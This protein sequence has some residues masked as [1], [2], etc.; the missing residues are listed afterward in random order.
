[1][2]APALLEAVREVEEEDERQQHARSQPRLPSFASLPSFATRLFA[3]ASSAAPP[4]AVP[5]SFSS[6]FFPHPAAA[7]GPLAVLPPPLPAASSLPA[8]PLSL[9]GAAVPR[10]FAGSRSPA[11]SPPSRKARLLKA[12]PSPVLSTGGRRSRPSKH[13]SASKEREAEE[14]VPPSPQSIASLSS[15]PSS[16]LSGSGSVLLPFTVEED[17]AFMAEQRREAGEMIAG[18]QRDGD[19]DEEE[20]DHRTCRYDAERFSSVGQFISHLKYVH[21]M[22]LSQYN[23]AKDAAQAVKKPRQ[24]QQKRFEQRKKNEHHCELCGKAFTSLSRLAEHYQQHEAAF[25]QEDKVKAKQKKAQPTASQPISPIIAPSKPRVHLV[26]RLP[27]PPQPTDAADEENTVCAVCLSGESTDENLIMFCDGPCRLAYHQD[28]IGADYVPEGNWYCS[29]RCERGEQVA[30]FARWVKDRRDEYERRQRERIAAQKGGGP[31]ETDPAQLMLKGF[32]EEVDGYFSLRGMVEARELL[33]EALLDES[34]MAAIERGRSYRQQWAVDDAREEED[35]RGAFGGSNR[36][37]QSA[38]EAAALRAKS[39]Q[40]E[41][42]EDDDEDDEE[43]EAEVEVEEIEQ[44]ESAMTMDELA[45]KRRKDKLKRALSYEHSSDRVKRVKRRGRKEPAIRLSLYA[46]LSAKHDDGL[47][48]TT[49]SAS[50]ASFAS[51]SQAAMSVDSPVSSAISLSQSS[52]VSSTRGSPLTVAEEEPPSRTLSSPVPIT[53]TLTSASDAAPTTSSPQPLCSRSKSDGAASILPMPSSEP[54]LSPSCSLRLSLLTAP[55]SS[56]AAPIASPSASQ[57]GKQPRSAVSLS[58]SHPMSNKT[59]RGSTTGGKAPRTT[60]SAAV[61]RSPMYDD[62]PIGDPSAESSASSSLEPPSSS[63]RGKVPTTPLGK[64]NH[65][66]PA[67][68]QSTKAPHTSAPSLTTSNE[69]E[70][71]EPIAASPALFFSLRSLEGDYMRSVGF[72]VSAARLS[73]AR[74]SGA[75]YVFPPFVYD[76]H[77][78]TMEDDYDEKEDDSAEASETSKEE[79][80]T[81]RKSDRAALSTLELDIVGLAPHEP[82]ASQSIAV[83]APSA[84]QPS[85]APPT[86]PRT[87]H[88][89]TQRPSRPRAGSLPSTSSHH[90]SGMLTRASAPVVPLSPLNAAGSPLAVPLGP[91]MSSSGRPIRLTTRALSSSAF[92]T[93]AALAATSASSS[94]LPSTPLIEL[95]S[96]ADTDEVANELWLCQQSY[97]AQHGHNEH[98]KAHLL[99]VVQSN[100]QH[101]LAVTRLPPTFTSLTSQPALLRV[102]WER[103]RIQRE[104]LDYFAENWL[105]SK[106]WREYMVQ[107]EEAE[108][109]GDEVADEVDEAEEERRREHR[110]LRRADRIVQKMLGEVVAAVG[111]AVKQG[112]D[113]LRLLHKRQKAERRAKKHEEQIA[114][115]VKGCMDW[116]LGKIV[117]KEQL[118]ERRARIRRM[119]EEEKRKEIEKE[120]ERRKERRRRRKLKKREKRRAEREKERQ[121]MARLLRRRDKEKKRRRR[122]KER[123]K[124]RAKE[125]EENRLRRKR[126][127]KKRRRRKAESSTSDSFSSSD[128]SSGESSSA[129]ERSVS[130]AS[131]SERSEEEEKASSSSSASSDDGKGEGQ[132]VYC[133]CRQ[134]YNEHVPMIGCDVCGEWYHGKCVSL[135]AAEMDNIDSYVC[136]KCEQHDQRRTSYINQPHEDGLL[137]DDEQQRVPAIRLKRVG[138]MEIPLTTEGVYQAEGTVEGEAEEKTAEKRVVVLYEIVSNEGARL[139][140]AADDEMLSQPL[141]IHRAASLKLRLRRLQPEGRASRRL[142]LWRVTRV[143]S[144]NVYWARESGLNWHYIRETNISSKDK[145]W[146]DAP[147]VE[148]LYAENGTWLAHEHDERQRPEQLVGNEREGRTDIGPHD[149]GQREAMVEELTGVDGLAMEVEDDSVGEVV[150]QPAVEQQNRSQKNGPLRRSHKRKTAE[151]PTQQRVVQVLSDSAQ[152]DKEGD[153]KLNTPPV[154]SAELPSLPQSPPAPTARRPPRPRMSEA[155]RLMTDYLNPP[156]TASHSEDDDDDDGDEHTVDEQVEE[157]DASVHGGDDTKERDA[158]HELSDRRTSSR[159]LSAGATAKREKREVDGAQEAEEAEETEEGNE[160]AHGGLINQRRRNTRSQVA[161][162]PPVTDVDTQ[163]RASFGPPPTAAASSVTAARITRRAANAAPTVVEPHRTPGLENSDTRS[164]RTGREKRKQAGHSLS[165]RQNGQTDAGQQT[166]EVEADLPSR[167]RNGVT[168]SPGAAS[169]SAVP[170]PPSPPSSQPSKRQRRNGDLALIDSTHIFAQ[171]SRRAAADTHNAQTTTHAGQRNAHSTHSQDAEDNEADDEDSTAEQQQQQR[172]TPNSEVGR[173]RSTRAKPV[174]AVQPSQPAPQPQRFTARSAVRNGHQ[175]TLHRYFGR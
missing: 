100:V 84:L 29:E 27:L 109:K 48:S 85:S 158:E 9:S 62:A 45:E 126:R 77:T 67:S 42:E 13:R 110:K 169:K 136:A 138:V 59:P 92:K 37:R 91:N 18:D 137:G 148:N 128:D 65:P 127:D 139:A 2:F 147:G 108:E 34:L 17:E 47:D 38:A 3:V 21:S 75:G 98:V 141:S 54:A 87:P 160:S 36:R 51:S 28:C 135:T 150:A 104:V 80:K 39:L 88:S 118:R 130:S 143:V 170:V 159:R 63:P 44:D 154:E 94:T 76:P 115:R 64:H 73:E 117:A 23:K 74:E 16:P 114:R 40:D 105:S 68:H 149:D 129:S 119:G 8:L 12:Q 30:D 69:D 107:V 113:D 55:L 174:N 164:S 41:A 97:L 125:E 156:D 102:L 111:K 25:Q 95:L 103:R 26:S 46:H 71:K 168:S 152:A 14:H 99:R 43:Q 131:D 7:T 171:R 32:W 53:A 49:S 145:R 66:M 123:Q 31:R 78:Q 134:P 165:L 11:A 70:L 6:A 112:K 142:H 162:S 5:L 116:M 58:S 81:R 72:R 161:P 167:N 15:A 33:E 155:Q 60:V 1:M 89:L 163:S 4:P 133:Y 96:A 61:D 122:E 50:Y 146:T 172:A 86:S 24:S 144:K 151:A 157:D 173:R 175:D 22:T 52:P 57:G 132:E 83:P 121:R 56:G 19:G 124:Q 106:A 166:I 120:R 90:M 35:M 101:F 82:A 153:D 140:E 79:A 20:E 10:S 93:A